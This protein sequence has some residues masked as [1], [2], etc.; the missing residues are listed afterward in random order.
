[1]ASEDGLSCT[2]L[3]SSETG[4]CLLYGL[5]MVPRRIHICMTGRIL[6]YLGPLRGG[7]NSVGKMTEVMLLRDHLSWIPLL[8]RVAECRDIMP[9][10]S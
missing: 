1:V 9:K 10:V 7:P 3:V 4:L 2:K 5:V 6:R 8:C